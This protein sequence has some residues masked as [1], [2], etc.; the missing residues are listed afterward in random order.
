[1]QQGRSQVL[2]NCENTPTLAI[3]VTTLSHEPCAPPIAREAKQPCEFA[4]SALA[5][6]MPWMPWME[7]RGLGR[8][9]GVGIGGGLHTFAGLGVGWT[10]LL[11][12]RHSLMASRR[13]P[14]LVAMVA[15]QGCDGCSH[16]QHAQSSTVHHC[17]W[18]CVP[19]PLLY[20]GGGAGSQGRQHQTKWQQHQRGNGNG[21]QIQDCC[22]R[23]GHG[24]WGREHGV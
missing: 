7:A 3:N 23:M 17:T 11:A 12:C 20:R 13:P 2:P 6:W 5:W 22:S 18:R 8:A 14:V 16:E 4:S 21:V 9:V 24:A 10:A 15:G 1:M 19:P